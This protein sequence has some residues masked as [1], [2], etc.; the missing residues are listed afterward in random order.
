MKE[1][2][3]MKTPKGLGH[4][5]KPVLQPIV[6]KIVGISCFQISL[7]LDSSRGSRGAT[8]R[9]GDYGKIPFHRFKIQ[10]LLPICPSEKCVCVPF[11]VPLL[12]PPTTWH[13]S[14]GQWEAS[15]HK[16]YSVWGGMWPPTPPPRGHNATSAPCTL[17]RSPPPLNCTCQAAIGYWLRTAPSHWG[18]GGF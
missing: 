15:R 4:L 13:S 10:V 14:P 12:H 7:G 1:K 18:P 2:K 16:A 6:V 9:Q 3:K 8:L 17:S 11:S 5:K